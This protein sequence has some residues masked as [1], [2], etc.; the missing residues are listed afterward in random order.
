M[1]AEADRGR[2][3]LRS[4][5]GW[6][7]DGGHGGAQGVEAPM[8]GAAC[9]YGYRVYRDGGGCLLVCRSTRAIGD[10]D[11]GRAQRGLGMVIKARLSGE[12][13]AVGGAQG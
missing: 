11:R 5:G 1:R 9:W 10:G 3:A 7:A 4:Q 8:V 13:G 12:G 6:L 2:A